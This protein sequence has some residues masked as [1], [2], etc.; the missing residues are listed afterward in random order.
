MVGGDTLT[1]GVCS[2]DFALADIVKFI[3]HKVLTCN[4][5][6]YCKS[7]AKE[8]GTNNSTTESDAE[9]ANNN[10]NNNNN[11]DERRQSLSE[12]KNSSESESSEKSP[13]KDDK[14]NNEAEAMD[15]KD[16]EANSAKDK[17][18]SVK[19]EL[20][21][22]A[23]LAS[24]KRKADCVDVDTNTD[25]TGRSLR[26]KQWAFSSPLSNEKE[27]NIVRISQSIKL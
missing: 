8:N 19:N 17:L 20:E 16:K 26:E 11:S 15:V 1:C 27:L 3:Q 9:G 14:E 12:D 10:N 4:K 6:N 24:R 2:K 5:E 22:S 7:N 13:S 21:S 18:E 23:L 25:V